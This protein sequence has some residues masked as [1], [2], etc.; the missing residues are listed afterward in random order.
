MREKLIKIITTI[1]NTGKICNN[2]ESDNMTVKEK[3][4]SEKDFFENMA[5]EI[6]D[7]IEQEQE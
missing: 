3:L 1:Y 7:L 4:K 5:D 2:L 6:I